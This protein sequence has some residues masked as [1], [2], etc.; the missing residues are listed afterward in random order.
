[1]GRCRGF[2]FLVAV[3]NPH[4]STT[5]CQTSIHVAPAISY[6]ERRSQVNRVFPRCLENQAGFWFSTVAFIIARVVAH[7][8]II[9][10]QAASKKGVHLF[11]EI[12]RLMPAADVRLVGDNE[13]AAGRVL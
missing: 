7:E 6:Q 11:D 8:D 4:D 13:V 3:V 5:G 2:S 10:R 9:N 1:M 12:T